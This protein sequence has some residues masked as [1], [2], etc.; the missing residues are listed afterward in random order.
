MEIIIPVYF[1]GGYQSTPLVMLGINSGFS[2]KNNPIEN[3]E[4]RSTRP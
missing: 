2:S 4:A 1:V 3:Q